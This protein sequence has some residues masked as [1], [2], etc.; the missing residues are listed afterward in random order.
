MTDTAA[1]I[2][3]LRDD[4]LV[5]AVVLAMLNTR[6]AKFDLKPMALQKLKQEEIRLSRWNDHVKEA[7]SAI[8]AYDNYM[9][10]RFGAQQLAGGGFK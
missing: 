1:L 10:Q 9:I 4:A 7:E 2:A 3:G 8:R 6:R 5:E